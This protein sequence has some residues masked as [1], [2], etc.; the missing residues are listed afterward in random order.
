[1][2]TLPD[3][4]TEYVLCLLFNKE[5]RYM[6]TIQRKEKKRVNYECP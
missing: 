3:P 6:N 1:M 4:T 5:A 2:M